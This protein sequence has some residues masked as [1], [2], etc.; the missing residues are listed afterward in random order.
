MVDVLEP[1]TKEIADIK[2]DLPDILRKILI[3][4]KEQV[5]EILRKEQ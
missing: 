3:K 1:Y 2:R 5:L 4:N